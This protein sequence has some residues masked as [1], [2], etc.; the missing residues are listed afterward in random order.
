MVLDFRFTH[1]ARKISHF[2]DIT[3]EKATL[4]H[5]ANSE[6]N[7]YE[8]R[9]SISLVSQRLSSGFSWITIRSN[10]VLQVNPRFSAK[11]DFIIMKSTIAVITILILSGFSGFPDV[12]IS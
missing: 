3:I 11:K 2:Y 1:P 12:F 6:K 7:L 4:I 9:T 5:L 10:G 8:V